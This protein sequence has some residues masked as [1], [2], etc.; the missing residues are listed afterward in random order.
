M[1]TEL[2]RIV[3]E[4]V[5][6]AVESLKY[7]MPSYAHHDVAIMHFAAAKAHVAVYGLVHVE[8]NVPAELAPYLT[9]RSTL[10]FKFGDSL[11][12]AALS[13]TLRSKVAGM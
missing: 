12:S 13:E 3:F 7:G 1:L 11:P 9:H 5:P 6:T 2:R 4:V 10:Q 8:G